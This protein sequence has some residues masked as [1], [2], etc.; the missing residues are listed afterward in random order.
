[1]DVDDEDD[2]LAIAP[3][4]K[5]EDGLGS[6]L[7]RSVRKVQ[8]QGLTSYMILRPWKR[9]LSATTSYASSNNRAG[10]SPARRDHLVK[11]KA[12]P[13]RPLIGKGES[14]PGDPQFLVAPV[15]LGAMDDECRS[16]QADPA[17]TVPPRL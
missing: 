17:D 1:M 12:R 14:R 9:D 2:G 3:K 10:R 16:D 7:A 15:D 11:L 4:K 6:I 5:L 8:K 13:G